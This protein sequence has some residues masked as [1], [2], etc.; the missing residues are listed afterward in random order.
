MGGVHT[1]QILEDEDARMDPNDIIDNIFPDTD[2]HCAKTALLCLENTQNMLGG[3]ALSPSY[4]S[5]LGRLA[6]ENHLKS[7]V[8]GARIFNAAVAQKVSVK[9]L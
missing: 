2:D 8:D 1:R 9:E 3:V 7:H 5:E 6:K 4:M